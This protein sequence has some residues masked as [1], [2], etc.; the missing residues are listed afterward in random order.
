MTTFI[1]T[2][3]L[4]VTAFCAGVFAPPGD[5]EEYQWSNLT[6]A[7]NYPQS[8]NYPVYVFGNW[9]VAINNGGW[10]SNDGKRW[11]KTS[12][13]DSGLNSAYQKYVQFNGAVYA[14]GSISGNYQRF[15]I[16]TKILRTTDFNK[17]ETVAERSNLPQ[18]VFYGLTVFNGRMWMLGGYDGTN[19]HNDVWTSGDG[20]HWEQLAR[21]AEW[22][23]RNIGTVA[24]FKNRLWILGGG[25]LDGDKVVNPNSQN[26]VWSS[27]DGICWKK[28]GSKILASG[29]YV[30]G[31]VAVYDNKL[32]IVGANRNNVFQSGVLFSEDGKVWNEMTAPWSPRGA[33]ATWVYKDRLFMTGGKSSHTENGEIKFV[34]SNDV[35]AMERK[36]E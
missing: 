34:Y 33:V 30:G 21:S 7:A 18:R 29:N 22:S 13:P 6:K 11:V 23:P 16:S 32:W 24:V 10:L 2:A 9:M 20:V 19:Y 4:A 17:W 1:A 35:W 26:E 15:T 3:F 27:V 14:L 5:G 25:E 36:S 28:E 12:L 8:Y 31:T